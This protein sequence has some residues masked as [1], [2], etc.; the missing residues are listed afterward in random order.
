MIGDGIL[1]GDYVMVESRKTCSEGET[2]VAMVDGEV[3]LK[4]FYL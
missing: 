3:T 1:D 2:V 4:R